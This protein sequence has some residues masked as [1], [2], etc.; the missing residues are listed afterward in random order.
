MIFAVNDSKAAVTAAHCD[1]VS[2]RIAFP[3]FNDTLLV[4]VASVVLATS[5]ILFIR[6]MITADEEL[7]PRFVLR[8]LVEC[9][10]SALLF[11]AALPAFFLVKI[12]CWINF[13]KFVSITL[14]VEEDGFNCSV[15]TDPHD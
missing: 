12:L 5:V 13:R 15:V 14:L 3:S 1:C 6:A 8:R 11:V 2:Y 7:T 4:V 9:A 10:V